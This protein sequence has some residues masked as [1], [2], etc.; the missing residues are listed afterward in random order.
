MIPIINSLVN[1][2]YKNSVKKKF[3]KIYRNNLFGGTQS[4]SGEGSN[5]IQTDVIRKEIPTLLNELKV[6]SLIDSPC[7]D[8]LWMQKADLPVEQYI[9]IDIV[10][11]II[12]HNQA[13]YSSHYR[14]FLEMNIEL[15]GHS[16]I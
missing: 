11:D 8:F 5:F 10:K 14:K 9:G 12:K 1:F 6:K 4:R 15:L 7:G 3:T 13:E 2:F 16:K